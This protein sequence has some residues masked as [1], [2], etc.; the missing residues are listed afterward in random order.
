MNSR[1]GVYDNQ[2]LAQSLI[3]DGNYRQAEK[4]IHN[5]L[6]RKPAHFQALLDCGF[7]MVQQER[8][9][10]ALVFF[11]RALMAKVFCPGPGQLSYMWYL[12]ST[13]LGE[14]NRLEEALDCI[15]RAEALLSSYEYGVDEPEEYARVRAELLARLEGEDGE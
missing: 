14:L 7:T 8:Y 15:G 10:D 6:R 4:L 1:R 11:R 2:E 5:T 13:S 12:M 9:E 3:M